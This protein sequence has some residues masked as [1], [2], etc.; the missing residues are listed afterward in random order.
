M[1]KHLEIILK[2]MCSRVND[3]Y[4]E[5]DFKEDNWYWK[6][7]WTQ[8]EENSFTDWL[9]GYLLNNKEA[10]KEIMS[11]PTTNKEAV[12]KIALYFTSNFGWKT[13]L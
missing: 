12:G 8:E 2:E 9:K 1:T 10:R 3:N 7:E 5:I 4:D 13:K 6:Y 11:Y